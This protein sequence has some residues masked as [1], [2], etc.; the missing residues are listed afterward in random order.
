MR[1]YTEASG[2]L[3][4]SYLLRA[5]REAGHKAVASDVNADAI[6]RYLADD[7]VLLPAATDPDLWNYTCASLLRHRVNLVIPSLDE[8]LSGWAVRRD[9]ILRSM[10]I[11]VIISE[12]ATVAACQD[13]WRTYQ[14]FLNHGIPTPRTSLLQEYPLVKPRFGRGS[15][16]VS[17]PAGPVSMTGM[18][19]QELLVGQE[20]TVDV[21]CDSSSDPV[22]II[23]RKRLKVE[24]G[25]S[26]DG[27][28]DMHSAIIDWVK[29][30]C[31][32]MH[33]L[34]PVNIQCF[35]D[36]TDQVRFTEIN[37]RIAGGMAL[38][39]AASENWVTLLV[40]HFAHGREI[41]PVPVKNGLRMKRY[42][43]ELFVPQH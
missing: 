36:E 20:Y 42:Y 18:I 43:A 17:I 33:F 21:F 37:P 32:T 6:G 10:G 2:S 41:N 22:Y 14:T 29:M 40:D 23:P 5:I 25:K 11:H 34:G 1:I 4:S 24:S 8:S 30:I 16:G 3:V 15:T 19:S 13:K 39:F 35:V 27:V 12:P 31:K 9:E 28:V 38:S 26:I 7:F